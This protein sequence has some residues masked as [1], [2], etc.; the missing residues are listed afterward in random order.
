M[1]E[2]DR[3]N[4]L[5][6]AVCLLVNCIGQEIGMANIKK[7]QDLINDAYVDDINNNQKGDDNVA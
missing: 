7:L 1:T 3:I 2:S 5:C 4:K 6:E